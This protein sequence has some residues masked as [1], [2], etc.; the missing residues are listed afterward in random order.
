MSQPKKHKVKIVRYILDSSLGWWRKNWWHKVL[1]IFVAI[2]FACVGVMYGIAEWYINS[3]KNV[4]YNLGVTYIP[5]Y[6]QYYGLDP[7]ATLHA[8]LTQLGITNIRFV[9]YWSDIEPSP[10]V[11]DFSE[12][13]NEFAQAQAA[14]MPVS[15]SIGLRQPR[16]PEC[17]MPSWAA[18]ETEAQWYPQLKTFMAAVINRYKNSPVLQS[19][20]LENE[21]FLKAFG[22][23]TNFSRSRLIDEYNFVKKLDPKHPIIISRSNNAVGLPIGKP[24]PDEFGVS[25]YKRVWDKSI[26]HRY[27]EY[28]IPAWFYGFLAGAGKLLTGKN[29]IIH[30]LQAEPWPPNGDILST[31][32]AEQNLSMNAQILASRF[33]Y[34]EATGIKTIDLWGVEWWYWRMVDQHDPSLW[35]TAKAQFAWAKAQNAKL[36]H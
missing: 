31:S 15:L 10:G 20:Q 11:F 29:M 28:P 7:V 23:C 36:N 18:N 5:D 17:H 13:D 32:I 33:K 1:T 4:P 8:I 24:T 14:D 22:E 26:T 19:Y 27:F 12:L 16:W 35:N 21:Y 2:V 34:G 30:E 6:A 3:Q 9:S 25:V